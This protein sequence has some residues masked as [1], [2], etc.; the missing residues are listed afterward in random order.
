MVSFI[1]YFMF[2]NSVHSFIYCYAFLALVLC[3]LSNEKLNDSVQGFNTTVSTALGNSLN[4]ID[5]TQL[6]V[7]YDV[8][9]PS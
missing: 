2:I 5:D 1:F 8:S 7:G 6:V 3:L 9:Q 4:L